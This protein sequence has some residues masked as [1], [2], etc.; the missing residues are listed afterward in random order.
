MLVCDIW[1]IFYSYLGHVLLLNQQLAFDP[2]KEFLSFQSGNIAQGNQR[3]ASVGPDYGPF[4][5][6]TQRA[7]TFLS[8]KTAK[9]LHASKYDRLIEFRFG[10][11][12]VSLSPFWL[13]FKS[14][15]YFGHP[16]LKPAGARPL[17]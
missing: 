13:L 11:T 8:P 15:C 9:T 12:F 7:D 17:R 3:I 5:S 10:T 2:V 16:L 6:S 1:S 14:C 4:Y